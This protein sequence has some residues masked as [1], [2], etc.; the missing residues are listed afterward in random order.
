MHQSKTNTQVFKAGFVLAGFFA[1]VITSTFLPGFAITGTQLRQ[2]V[3]SPSSLSSTQMSRA[4][5]RTVSD[6]TMQCILV[7]LSFLGAFVALVLSRKFPFIK[8]TILS[9]PAEQSLFS[10]QIS[11][12][13]AVRGPSFV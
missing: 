1:F 9:I 10:W 11:A 4:E 8:R 2:F 6:E 3:A 5:Q 12:F 7:L 13:P